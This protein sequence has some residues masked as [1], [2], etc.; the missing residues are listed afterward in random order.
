MNFQDLPRTTTRAQFKSMH[1][2][3]RFELRE[4]RQCQDLPPVF[5]AMWRDYFQ[6]RYYYTWESRERSWAFDQLVI[7]F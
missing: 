2:Q 4:A 1:E 5:A 7:P 6:P 3:I